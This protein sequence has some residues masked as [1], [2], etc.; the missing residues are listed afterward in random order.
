VIFQLITWLLSS[1][2]LCDQYSL[3]LIETLILS[4]Q[5]CSYFEHLIIQVQKSFKHFKNVNFNISSMTIKFIILFNFPL[6]TWYSHSSGYL[7]IQNLIVV[8]NIHMVFGLFGLFMNKVA[9]LS[10]TLWRPKCGALSLY[11]INI[12]GCTHEHSMNH[13]FILVILSFEICYEMWTIR[14]Y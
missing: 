7:S 11:Y 4:L 8:W 3:L 1:L 12:V 9:I 13:I 6:L 14:H 10:F 2:Y 5:N